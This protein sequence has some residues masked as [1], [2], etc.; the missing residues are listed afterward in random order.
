MYSNW[1]IV[2]VASVLAATAS[3]CGGDG[4]GGGMRPTAT[5][6]STAT[7]TPTPSP[8]PIPDCICANFINDEP[9]FPNDSDESCTEFANSLECSNGELGDATVLCGDDASVPCCVA[10]DCQ[11]ECVCPPIENPFLS[12]RVLN[13]A[14]RGGNVLAPEATL[15]AFRSAVELGVDVLEMDLRGTSDGGVIVM[16]D[17]TVDRTTNGTGRIEDLTLAEI[18]ALDAGYDYT[19]DGGKT[20]PFRGQGLQVP[21][22]EEVLAT[23]PDQYMNPEIKI[24][25]PSIVSQVV[26]TLERYDMKD[27]VLVASFDNAIIAEF[28][29]AAPDVLTSYSLGEGIAFYSLTPEQEETYVPPAEFLQV[30]PTLESITVLTPEFLA[31]ARRFGIR[32]HVW[33]VDD[34]DE[35]NEIIDLDVDGLIVDDPE[36]LE[37]ILEERGL[38]K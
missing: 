3:G 34:A 10:H 22:F 9:L 13:I 35:M 20:F 8:T 28:R 38:A 18:R 23:F 1:L 37:G 29:A 32:I 27:K 11:Q 26:D 7:S 30:P 21:T 6:T 14:H 12:D 25:G 15:A 31:R 5:A 33:D 19:P 2:I 36:T 17:Q 24:E 4:D 16:H